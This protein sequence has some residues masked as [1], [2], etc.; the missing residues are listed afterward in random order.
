MAETQ[1]HKTDILD[2]DVEIF[3]FVEELSSNFPA[4]NLT[5]F[6]ELISIV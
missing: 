6:E 1:V 4:N 5:I 2:V 3:G